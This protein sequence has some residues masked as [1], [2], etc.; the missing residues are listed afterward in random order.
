MKRAANKSTCP[1]NLSL[2]VVGDTWSLLIIRDMVFAKKRS[3]R[4]FLAS[5]EKIATN[6]LN[7]RLEHLVEQGIISKSSHPTDMRKDIYRLTEKGIALVPMLIELADWSLQFNPRAVGFEGL[8]SATDKQCAIRD[9]H[10][11]LRIEQYANDDNNFD[12]KI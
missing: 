5:E 10:T 2:E 6:I 8:G 11:A 1:I 4:E 9:I 3:F 12:Q 7:S